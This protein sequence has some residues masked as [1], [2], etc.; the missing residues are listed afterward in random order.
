MTPTSITPRRFIHQRPSVSR[1]DV[2]KS[3]LSN[4]RSEIIRVKSFGYPEWYTMELPQDLDSNQ[5]TP[6]YWSQL[7]RR[8][9]Q[10]A[11]TSAINE[12]INPLKPASKY[13][14]K[15]SISFVPPSGARL[16]S[17]AHLNPTKGEIKYFLRISTKSSSRI[18][19]QGPSS[20]DNKDRRCLNGAIGTASSAS[21]IS[22]QEGTWDEKGSAKRRRGHIRPPTNEAWKAGRLDD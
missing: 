2:L 4:H 20:S 9:A 13:A 18:S 22:P 14:S 1:S 7:R 10:Q 12:G 17:E 6:G 11:D 19:E 5:R 8:E 21:G 3:F 16:N 15:I